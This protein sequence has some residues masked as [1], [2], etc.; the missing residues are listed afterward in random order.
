MAITVSTHDENP[1]PG[2]RPFNTGESKFFF[3]REAEIRD[4][5]ARLLNNNYVTV[6]GAA[7]TGKSSLVSCGVVS[8]LMELKS[9]RSSSWKVVTFR[10]GN[11]AFRNLAV[12]LKDEF[13]DKIDD[14][15]KLLSELQAEGAH[16]SAVL[17]RINTSDDNILIVVDQLEDLFRFADKSLSAKTEKDFAGLLAASIANHTPNI[18]LILTLRSEF[19]GECSHIWELARIINNSNYIVPEPDM[20]CWKEIL[21]G[22]VNVSEGKIDAALEEKVLND[23]RF[24]NEM[25]PVLQHTMSRT[26]SLWHEKG[27]PGIPITVDDYNNAGTVDNSIS[28]HAEEIYNSFSQREREICAVLF[29]TITRKGPDGKGIRQ[30]ANIETI[31]LIAGCSHEEFSSVIDKFMSPGSSFITKNNSLIDIRNECIIH[32]W[33]RL[34]E[35]IDDEAFSKQMYLKISEASALYH[36]GKKGLYTQPE[37]MEAITWRE[38]FKPVLHWG[39]QYDPAF[40]RALVYLKTSENEYIE[41]E[42]L[43][44][45]LEENAKKR[46]AFV[47]TFSILIISVA[48]GL[49]I[50]AYIQKHR[51]EKLYSLTE[52]QKKEA[53][54]LKVISDSAAAVSVK[55]KVKSDSIAAEAIRNNADANRLLVISNKKTELARS[56]AKEASDQKDIAL[57]QKD[58]A[59]GLRMLSVGKA[60]SLKS[61]QLSAQKDLQA[62]LSYQAYLFNKRNNGSD[63]DPDI[64]AGLY[65]VA[66]QNGAINYKSYKGHQGDIKSVV[67]V[68][69]KN[70][71]FTSGTDG[72][73][74]KWA[75]EK[76]DQA[77]QVMYSGNDITEVLAVSPDAS[78]LACGTSNS[79]IRM[80]PLKG[81]NLSYE[82][83]GH[84]GK[85]T[86]LIFSF[87]GK[88]LY[89]AA[90]DG[91]VLKWDIA[92]RTSVNV[93]TGSVE[94]SSL[95][96]SSNGNYLAGIS[97]DGNV[98]VWTP[99]DNSENFRIE[100]S[101]KKINVIR[102]NPNKNMLAL[103]DTDG[104]VEIWDVEHHKMI[105]AF[106]AHDS[107]VNDI[108]FNTALNQ[109]ATAGIDKK[110]KIFSVNDQLDFS[111]PP[112]EF[113]DNDD[114]VLVMR[115][116]SDG[117]MLVSGGKGNNNLLSRATNVEY[118]AGEIR[119]LV[120]RN[121]TADEWN[122][123][124]GRDIPREKTVQEVNIK[125]EPRISVDKK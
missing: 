60:M 24:K 62:L 106:K 42:K 98:L 111:E 115:F 73:V 25:F 15:E 71:F 28:L 83:A 66:L 97:T 6:L 26:W 125:V 120:T 82:M 39:I 78:W 68:P 59:Q 79:S 61:L 123:Y 50:F 85:I 53:L 58:K 12:A 34:R 43:K 54:R 27:N 10:P 101:G 32:K 44:R 86:S 48:V 30:A 5:T 113:S 95:D 63:N 87:D 57:T 16:L 94:I 52:I 55:Q 45:K 46:S 114:F 76:Q 75:L 19:M 102:F 81:N 51:T 116:S 90:V 1:F 70:Q 124:V 92:A 69:G 80:I 105:S 72:K 4:I 118:L 37:L 99:G 2:L 31:K 20:D 41:E 38:K 67:F 11:D 103:G 110:I 33:K 36:Q 65:N 3:G 7:G 96:I 17:K 88:Y 121:M 112:L 91:K 77:L 107:Q 21:N 47:T 35:W 93:N 18:Y 56:M 13:N 117:Q 109:M 108:Q 9:K 40:E 23:I 74:L 84:S 122:I 100:I 14:I 8:K 64:Y 119:D 29:R 89:S 22:P 49:A 104:N